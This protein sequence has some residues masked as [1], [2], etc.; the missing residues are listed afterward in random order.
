ML[1]QSPA[2]CCNRIVPCAW[3]STTHAICNCMFECTCA[4]TVQ[5]AWCLQSQKLDDAVVGVSSGDKGQL[6][7]SHPDPAVH[8]LL[9]HR[10]P[11]VCSARYQKICLSLVVQQRQ[12]LP[13][14]PLQA[15]GRKRPL[16]LQ[17]HPRRLRP[18]QS[19]RECL[20]SPLQVLLP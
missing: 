8:V 17:A 10:H 12:H 6:P 18:P 2:D 14:T 1:Q 9:M 5:N 7:L 15:A 20:R 16:P 13:F 19:L 4:C 3:T 11:Q